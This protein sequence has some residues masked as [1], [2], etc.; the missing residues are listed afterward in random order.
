MALYEYCWLCV[1]GSG[2]IFKH[3]ARE[4]HY[5]QGNQFLI[6]VEFTGIGVHVYPFSIDLELNGIPFGS[7]SIGKK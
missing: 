7:K 2:V 6:P 4:M 5:S 1:E 3:F